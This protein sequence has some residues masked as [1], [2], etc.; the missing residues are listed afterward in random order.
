MR[1]LARRNRDHHDMIRPGGKDFQYFGI[2]TWLKLICSLPT[3]DLGLFCSNLTDFSSSFDSRETDQ[4]ALPRPFP[5][6]QTDPTR[7]RIPS[8]LVDF[9]FFQRDFHRPLFADTAV[10]LRRTRYTHASSLRNSLPRHRRAIIDHP[11]NHNGSV[12]VLFT[13]R[14]A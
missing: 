3:Q 10:C 2:E 12:T 4:F 8:F 5:A 13:M 9:R 7:G 14:S 11:S 6:S 1:P